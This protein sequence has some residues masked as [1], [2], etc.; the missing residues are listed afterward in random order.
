MSSTTLEALTAHLI[1]TAFHRD[2]P[3][4]INPE[5]AQQYA[6]H[7]LEVEAPKG[8]CWFGEHMVSCSH[9]GV[10]YTM[11]AHGKPELV[12]VGVRGRALIIERHHDLVKQVYEYCAALGVGDI[13]AMCSGHYQLAVYFGNSTGYLACLYLTHVDPANN[14]DEEYLDEEREI[15]PEAFNS[16]GEPLFLLRAE[17]EKND[18]LFEDKFAVPGTYFETSRSVYGNA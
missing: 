2:C 16:N 11:D 13:W 14:P 8:N 1:K 15:N 9:D 18:H 12:A 6:R 5:L 17:W 4:P 3:L 7:G 10:P